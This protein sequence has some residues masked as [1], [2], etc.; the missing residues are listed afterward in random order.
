M[1]IEQWHASKEQEVKELKDLWE[2]GGISES[3]YKELVEDILDIAKIQDDLA[4]EDLKNKAVKAIDAIKVV[5][6]LI[7]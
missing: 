3:E 4:T 7:A 1:N 2:S 6:G 5:A